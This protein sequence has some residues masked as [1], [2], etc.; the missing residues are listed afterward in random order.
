M[1]LERLGK[2]RQ[3]VVLTV[4]T[5]GQIGGLAKTSVL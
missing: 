2:Q 4:V 5:S 3:T 1:D